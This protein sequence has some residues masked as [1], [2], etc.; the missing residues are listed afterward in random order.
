[1]IPISPLPELLRGLARQETRPQRSER[2]TQ[3]RLKAIAAGITEP[4]DTFEHFVAA[5]AEAERR[6]FCARG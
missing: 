2:F 4:R 3:L 1:M 5:L 6:K